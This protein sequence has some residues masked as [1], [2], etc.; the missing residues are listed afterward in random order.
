MTRPGEVALIER[1]FAPLAHDPAALSLLDDT[2]VLAVPDGRELVVTA[3]AL[4]A[5]IHFFPDDPPGAIARKALRV[6]LSDLAAKAAEPPGYL[7][8]IALAA[9]WTEDWLA[10]FAAG[11]A[12]DQAEFG[13]S[14]LGGDTIRTDGPTTLS[15]TALGTVPK[16]RAL[17]RAA[18]RPGDIVCVSGT[19]GDAALGLLLRKDR[20]RGAALGLA[21][22]E[23]DF[24]DDRYLLP[25]PRLGLRAAIAAHGRAGIDV[26]DGL[27]TD[28]GKLCRAAGTGADLD[29]AAIPLSPAARVALEHDP[30]LLAGLIDGGDDYEIV[31]TC[32]AGAVEA[33][34]AAAAAGVPLTPIGRITGE[35]GIVRLLDGEGA[36][37]AFEKAGYEHF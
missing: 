17:L 37:I 3:D 8:T 5:G 18:A 24:L 32:E 14:L 19:I 20:G 23:V 27:V 36:E 22:G 33:L 13:V 4:A 29:V 2:A 31:V 30:A 28:L 11:L 16:G 34:V 10:G 21:A 15:I 9:D 7:L 35:A 12:A 1:F 25:R 6:N 26:S